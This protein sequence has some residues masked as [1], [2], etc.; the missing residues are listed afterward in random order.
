MKKGK[1]NS[2]EKTSPVFEKLEQL[3]KVQRIAI[4]AGLLILLVAGFVYFSY[5]PK[6]KKIEKLVKIRTREL[7]DLNESLKKDIDPWYPHFQPDQSGVS[8]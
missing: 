6:Y 3:T 2:I 1:A 5:L 7:K 4:W 8:F